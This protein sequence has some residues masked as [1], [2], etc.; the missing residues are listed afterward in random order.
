MDELQPF[1]GH[2]CQQNSLQRAHCFLSSAQSLPVE[3][4]GR[5]ALACAER[6][7]WEAL[8]TLLDGSPLPSMGVAPGLLAA[9]AEAGQYDLTARILEMVR[10]GMSKFDREVWWVLPPP[11]HADEVN[12]HG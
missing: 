2:F 5:L 10:R 11:S 7:R 1:V 12:A 6:G 4:T 8:T 9:A 3:L